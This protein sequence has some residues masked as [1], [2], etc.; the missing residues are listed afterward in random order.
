M[1][2]AQARIFDVKGMVEIFGGSGNTQDKGGSPPFLQS[3][4]GS[5]S[6]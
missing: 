6:S 3:D 2:S 5:L 4:H 1:P